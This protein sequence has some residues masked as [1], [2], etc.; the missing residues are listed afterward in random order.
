VNETEA[1]WL[2]DQ[3]R[4]T[5]DAAELHAKLGVGM[6]RTLGERGAEWAA[7]DDGGHVAAHPIKVVDT[8]AAGDCFAG[9]LAAALDRGMAMKQA[10]GRASVAAG[11]CCSRAGSQNSL[12]AGSGTDAAFGSI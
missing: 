10:M 7:Q 1:E 2:A 4:A 8:T 9:V 11:L 3:H 12:P 5:A 6:V